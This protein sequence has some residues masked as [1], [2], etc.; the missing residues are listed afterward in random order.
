ML[1]LYVISHVSCQRVSSSSSFAPTI[2]K[3]C[4][5][6]IAG[7]MLVH[8]VLGLECRIVVVGPTDETKSRGRRFH[9][10]SRQKLFQTYQFK[11]IQSN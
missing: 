10:V 1:R 6:S 2:L 3:S 11:E 5:L 7:L 8:S 4:I 9:A